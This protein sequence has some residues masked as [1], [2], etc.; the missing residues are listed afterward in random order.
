MFGFPL[1]VNDHARVNSVSPVGIYAPQGRAPVHLN[2]AQTPSRSE[3]RPDFVRGFGLE[4][5]EEEEPEEEEQRREQEQETNANEN[6]SIAG[7]PQFAPSET[8]AVQTI[9]VPATVE[10]PEEVKPAVHTR[11]ASRISVALSIGSTKQMEAVVKGDV[12]DE[13]HVQDEVVEQV[14]QVAESDAVDVDEWTGSEDVQSDEEVSRHSFVFISGLIVYEQSIGE[15]SNPSDEER[16]RQA[17]AQRRMRRRMLGDPEVP[18][19]IPNFPRPPEDSYVQSLPDDDEHYSKDVEDD[20][21]SNP[22]D[23]EHGHRLRF[24]GVR[25]SQLYAEIT[26]PES[27]QGSRPLPPL[28]HSRNGSGHWSYYSNAGTQSPSEIYN[29]SDSRPS[30]SAHQ[31]SGSIS[32]KKDVSLNPHAKPFVF[33][34]ART[35][36][37]TLPSSTSLLN[38]STEANAASSTQQTP[39]QSSAHARRP[40][41]GSSRVLNA[42][43][44][45]FKPGSF[46]FTPPAGVPKLTFPEPQ[47]IIAPA[48]SH[49][50]PRPLPI[51]PILD[52]VAV[53]GREKRSRVSE[54][55]ASATDEDEDEDED[56]ENREHLSA[57]RFP[58]TAEAASLYRRSAPTSPTLKLRGQS[59]SISAPISATTAKPYT[60]SG[61][62]SLV[63]PTVPPVGK[64]LSSYEDSYTSDESDVE[65]QLDESE[66]RADV[67]AEIEDASPDTLHFMSNPKQKRAP[68]PLD[69]THPVSTNKV[70]AGL[71][72]NYVNADGDDRTRISTRAVIDSISDHRSQISLD[73]LSMPAISHK[74]SRARLNANVSSGVDED[75]IPLAELARNSSQTRRFERP[76]ISLGRPTRRMQEDEVSEMSES[77][78]SSPMRSPGSIVPPDIGAFTNGLRFE[79]H[80]EDVLDKKFEELRSELASN[81]AG[82][83]DIKFISS[84]TE[85]LVKDAI[86]MFRTQMR[87]SAERELDDDS[88]RDAR[89]ELDFE[90]IRN[91]VEQGHEDTRQQFQRDLVHLANTISSSKPHQVST[92]SMQ[93]LVHL[94]H[95]M[96]NNVMA[97]NARVSDRIAAIEATTSQTNPRQERDAIVYEVVHALT[98][99]VTSVQPEPLDYDSLT[100]RLSQAVKPH[101]SQL[102]DLASDKRETA[103]LIATRL[104]P[105][106]QT[107]TQKPPTVD[108][109]SIISEM[110]AAINKVIAPID[111]HVIK[112]QVADL[113]VERLD[114]R[115]SVRESQINL[116]NLKTKVS[117]VV[118]PIIKR[119][120][121]LVEDVGGVSR[122]QSELYSQT[123]DIL[124]RG[125]DTL[126]HLDDLKG[127]LSS[128][129]ATI[130]DVKTSISLN[131]RGTSDAHV[132]TRKYLERIETAL[133]SHSTV[134]ETAP[135]A[136]VQEILTV[137]RQILSELSPVP[138]T[139]ENSMQS[140]ELKQT[141]VM[142]RLLAI[143][144]SIEELHRQT[145]STT[146]LQAQLVKA[147]AA[148]GQIRVEKDNLN[149]RLAIAEVERDRLRAKVEEAQV[150]SLNHATEL[151]TLQARATEQENAMHSA[152]ERLKVADVNA[153]TQ[154]DR[155]AELE[156]ANRELVMEKQQLKSKVILQPISFSSESLTSD[157]F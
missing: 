29:Q 142:K 25:R 122:D 75:N 78:S 104:M 108:T 62:S 132:E 10:V 81:A 126:N 56:K 57:F 112:E 99:V 137:S 119:M 31:T 148:H 94:I 80:F 47:P 26:S 146:D 133:Q 111:A 12:A 79:N 156:K 52:V 45:E 98:P 72:K 43:A 38:A 21:I 97:S 96:K 30:S 89:G 152:L 68:I 35:A 42:A 88:R 11:H 61:F 134:A 93:E 59:G 100:T 135:S 124:E 5:P 65:Q 37:A 155:I 140:M 17:R 60:I 149:E 138:N 128:L 121:D 125:T 101:I 141:E 70:P 22:S 49:E 18:R 66:T 32:F 84:S 27:F 90:L 3:S 91:I 1:Q 6:A 82:G 113:V 51:P 95:D 76:S 114:A 13:E 4:I 34:G 58:P 87:A 48:V 23:E 116:E 154:H 44:Q 54:S 139:I 9:D 131:E 50:P 103:E 136:E 74:V 33:G 55:L 14:Q 69:F 73:D 16:A 15:W 36:L 64:D 144:E 8:T 63:P 39:E 130:D 28:P 107:F 150:T 20:I 129:V 118:L 143:Q 67:D 19:K 53:Q 117:E 24:S 86:A 71:F 102:I 153:Q 115:L 151:A 77:Q 92:D 105:I 127:Q 110:T 85:E 147:R 7:Q 106:L 109:E 123:A 145:T 46:T 40:S 120:D 2:V 157:I 41:L 83:Y